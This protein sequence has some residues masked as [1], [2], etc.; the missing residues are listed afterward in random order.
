[1]NT[2]FLRQWWIRFV[3]VLALSVVLFVP[4]SRV[5]RA[6]SNQVTL[7]LLTLSG[8]AWQNAMTSV[9]DAFEKIHPGIRI[10]QQ[11]VP[12]AQ[13]FQQIE[14]RL[15]SGSTTPDIISVDAPLVAAYT[16]QGFLTPLDRYFSKAD[17]AQFTA[18]PL[19]TSYYL[20]HLMAPPTNSSSQ[21][22]YYNKDVLKKAGV[23][24]PSSSPQHRLTWEQ[25]AAGARKAMVRSHGTISVYGLVIDQIDRIYQLQP[26]PTSLGGRALSPDGL[27]TAG[28]VPSPAWI[29]AMT[30]Y[31]D[32]F[33]KWDISPK[34]ATDA[35]TPQIFATGHTA[36]FWGG[37]W[38]ALTFQASKG[39]HWGF[40]PTP[41]F[42]GGKPVTPT[43][44]WH[45]G[46][47]RR[48]H[49][50]APAAA[51]VRFITVGPGADL[52][53]KGI[54]Q[55][56]AL[57]RLLH[58]INTSPAYATFP[59][60]IMR[61]AAYENV[62]TAVP[63]PVTPGYNEYQ[64]IMTTAFNNMRSGQQPAAALQ[65]ASASIDRALAKYRSL[66]SPTNRNKLCQQ[67]FGSSCPP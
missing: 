42:A 46:V 11:N 24:F 22:L 15:G 61:L 8:S 54:N 2:T 60:N 35:A 5:S 52:W 62:H 1:M 30:F 4:T 64:D 20:G 51:F 58:V 16:V 37:E 28:V 41:Y 32:L 57:K 9:V 63:R 23:P 45:I 66:L 25:V 18:A 56:P 31:W 65:T 34:A 21:A 27:R 33:N 13:L 29:K 39:L 55:F 38:N 67:L 50:V 7:V 40:A 12:F 48:S 17:L 26:L 6:A 3:A 53:W 36:L 10:V 44:S 43:D 47:N 19:S 59:N 14:V 49:N